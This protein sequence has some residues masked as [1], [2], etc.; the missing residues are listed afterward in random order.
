MKDFVTSQQRMSRFSPQQPV[1][2]GRGAVWTVL[3]V[4]SLYVLAIGVMAL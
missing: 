4:V 1:K 2:W 3:I